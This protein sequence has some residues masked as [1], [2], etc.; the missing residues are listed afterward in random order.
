MSKWLFFP[1]ASGGSDWTDYMTAYAGVDYAKPQVGVGTANTNLVIGDGSTTWTVVNN[2][3]VGGGTTQSGTVMPAPNY[4]WQSQIQS[5]YLVI[6]NPYDYCAVWFP[7]SSG[8]NTNNKAPG[9]VILE[10]PDPATVGNRQRYIP[11][12][13]SPD[14]AVVTIGDAYAG[15]MPS[16]GS[17]LTENIVFFFNAYTSGDVQN[18]TDWDGST[19]P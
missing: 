11:I 5:G 13:A 3:P 8:G 1:T 4:R 17:C 18:W 10:R 16:L 6:S 19:T 12:E 9:W 2:T 15:G 7:T 14:V